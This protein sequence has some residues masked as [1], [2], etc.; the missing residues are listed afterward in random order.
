MRGV[1]C[2]L[3]TLMEGQHRKFDMPNIFL[4]PPPN[5]NNDRSLV[6]LGALF[7]LRVFRVSRVHLYFDLSLNVGITGTCSLVIVGANQ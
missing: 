4:P 7:A 2:Y 5:I 1:T 3:H 6:I